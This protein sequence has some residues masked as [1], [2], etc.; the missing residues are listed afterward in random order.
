MYFLLKVLIEFLR[1]YLT[2]GFQSSTRHFDVI[3]EI[4]QINHL[5][6]E[7]MKTT[8]II[9]KASNTGKL[10]SGYRKQERNY[11]DINKDG[12]ADDYDGYEE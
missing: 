10:R 2:D 9:T 3:K 4:L 11:R 1:H 5:D 6:E 12:L 8:S 7:G